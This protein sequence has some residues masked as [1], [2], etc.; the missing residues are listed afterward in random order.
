MMRVRLFLLA[1]GAMFLGAAHPAP[2]PQLDSYVKDGHFYPGDYGWLRGLFKDAAP[3]DRATWLAIIQW[4]NECSNGGMAELRQ[5][6]TQRGFSDP[7]LDGVSAM[8]PLCAETFLNLRPHILRDMNYDDFALELEQARPVA[9]SYLFAVRMAEEA[10]VPRSPDVAE[11]LKRRIL[12]EQMLRRAVSWGHGP[13]AT[14]PALTAI[15]KMIVGDQIGRETSRR[16]RANTDWLKVIVAEQGWPTISKVGSDAAAAAFLLVQHADHDPV[17]QL[18]IL[19]L[20]EPLVANGEVA[21]RSYAYLYDRT[22]LKLN[23]QQRYGTQAVCIDG[24]FQP[25]P[26]EDE[27]NVDRLRTA[28]ELEPLAQYLERMFQ[29]YGSCNPAP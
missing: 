4:Q 23:G 1:L 24:S 29:S 16:D 8:P 6:L 11:L 20:I 17:F 10:N 14:A 21:P 19:R 12:G 13:A 2:P 3:A 22:M 26:L 9:E 28:V 7:P 18:D 25:R 27:A 15:G 5:Q